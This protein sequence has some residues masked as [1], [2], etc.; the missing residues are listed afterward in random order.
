MQSFYD[1]QIVSAHRSA[2][3]LAEADRERMVREARCAN[4]GTTEDAS[5]P[6][7]GRVLRLRNHLLQDLTLSFDKAEPRA[8]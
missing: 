4:T 1:L 7:V 3:R 8:T 6:L 5:L 2:Q